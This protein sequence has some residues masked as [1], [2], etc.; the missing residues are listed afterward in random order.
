MP[1]E[2]LTPVFAGRWFRVPAVFF[3]AAFQCFLGR[4]GAP[5][6]VA[7][8][9]D[10]FRKRL[11]G[12]GLT[13]IF[14]GGWFRVLAVL[15]HTKPEDLMGF[16]G[17][18]V[19]VTYLVDAAHEVLPGLR[20]ATFLTGRRRTLGSA[21]EETLNSSTKTHFAIVALGQAVI[22][23]G[24]RPGNALVATCTGGHASSIGSRVEDGRELCIPS[25]G[26]IAAALKE[27]HGGREERQRGYVDF[28]EVPT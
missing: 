10:A 16:S 27:Q 22:E 3:N 25:G 23:D 5:L 26:V 20:L 4:L 28:H 12:V 18:G 11:V 14:A 6:L 21:L 19:L 1:C 17:T 15:M 8:F 7:S 9:V 2:G 13:S 24:E